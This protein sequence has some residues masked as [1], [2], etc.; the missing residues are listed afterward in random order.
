MVTEIGENEV[1]KK[2]KEMDGKEDARK[3]LR[4]KTT[5]K[6]KKRGRRVAGKGS[7]RK[8]GWMG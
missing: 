1:E 4:E 8:M 7:D 6:E 3:S 2:Q 5:R